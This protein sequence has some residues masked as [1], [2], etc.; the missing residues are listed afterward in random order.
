VLRIA[1]RFGFSARWMLSTSSE[2][3]VRVDIRRFKNVPSF[4]C[5]IHPSADDII[6]LAF[7]LRHETLMG[8]HINNKKTF[9]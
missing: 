4:V 1:T 9:P 7:A 2:A 8:R 6:T 3:I 5:T